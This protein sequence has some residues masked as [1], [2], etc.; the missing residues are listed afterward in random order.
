MAKFVGRTHLGAKQSI[1]TPAHAFG[2]T[3]AA[4]A[5]LDGAG[6]HCLVGVVGTK[7]APDTREQ[8]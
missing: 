1:G 5:T 4:P 8:Q 2:G 6:V 7:A 3:S